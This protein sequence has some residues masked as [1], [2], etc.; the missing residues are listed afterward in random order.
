[1]PSVGICA[2]VSSRRAVEAATSTGQSLLARGIGVAL[3]D[4]TASALSLEGVSVVSRR[5]LASAVDILITFGGD[6]TLLS[7][8]RHAPSRVPVIGVN[9]GTLGFLTDIRASEYPQ[10][11]DDVLAGKYRA[12]A[13]STLDVF[14]NGA[15]GQLRYRVLNDAV[16][17]KG[18]LARIINLEVHVG[19]QLLSTFRADGLIVSTPTGSTA[20]NLSA[21]G[22]II[23]PTL[24]AVVITPICP[25]TLTNRPIVL[26]DNEPIEL[27]MTS[28][29]K[30]IF[31]TLDGQ[32]G[33]PLAG[34]ERIVIRR[35]RSSV[36]MVLSPSKGYFAILRSKLKWGEG[37]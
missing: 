7:A 32:E 14:V 9:M 5:D 33:I 34:N 35:A 8:A 12:E 27:S 30:K 13:R 31:L 4:D 23:H 26:P 20:Y 22:P 36:Q 24:R 15:N 16:L 18:A 28:P 2:K 19:G 29:D 1:M 10:V 25:H 3:D 11:L 6:G 21:G 37:K 17:N